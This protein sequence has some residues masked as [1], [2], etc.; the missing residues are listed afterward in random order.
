MPRVWV[1]VGSNIERELRIR[2][3]LDDMRA[4]FGELVI[5]PVYETEAVGFDGDPFLNL[6]VGIYSELPP[7]NLHG[8]MREIETRQGRERNGEKFSART[9]DLDVLTYGSVVTSDGG[10]ALPRDEILDYAFV[11]GP[12]ADVAGE[13]VY[14]GS[15]DT[16]ASLWAQM[17]TQKKHG[18]RRLDDVAWLES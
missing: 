10:K 17:D 5:S 13:E 2:A 8:L 16:Y 7:R 11:L 15:E 12:L 3:A 6:V 1:S 9:L 14:P 18:L 4:L